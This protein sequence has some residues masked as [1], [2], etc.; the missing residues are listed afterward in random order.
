LF[1]LMRRRPPFLL[2]GFQRADGG[3]D[4][5]GFTLLAAGDGAVAAWRRGRRV[6]VLR[7]CWR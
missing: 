4:V 3:E 6:G 7:C 5:A 2:D 1:F